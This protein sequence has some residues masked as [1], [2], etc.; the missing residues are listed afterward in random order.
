MAFSRRCEELDDA[1][2]K[3]QY[4]LQKVGPRGTPTAGHAHPSDR[5]Q[6]TPARKPIPR[7][8][9][10]HSHLDSPHLPL[11]TPSPSLTHSL[12]RRDQGCYLLYAQS[13][14]G[15][16]G[17]SVTGPTRSRHPHASGGSLR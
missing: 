11:E 5:T 17:P 15:F 12:N 16:K 6:D 14:P 9:R 10:T 3:L 1:R 13:R 2:H 4:H 7:L 8:G